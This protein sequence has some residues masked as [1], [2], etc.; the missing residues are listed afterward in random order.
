[1]LSKSLLYLKQKKTL[2]NQQI[3]LLL[4][5]FG[6]WSGKNHF[7]ISEK[8]RTNGPLLPKYYIFETIFLKL[9]NLGKF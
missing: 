7:Q 9:K 4:W 6:H 5:E 1:M 3:Q 8:V 2:N